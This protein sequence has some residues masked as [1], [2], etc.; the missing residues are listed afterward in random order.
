MV[1]LK[2]AVFTRLCEPYVR[3]SY[4]ENYEPDKGDTVV[5]VDVGLKTARS[6]GVV[7]SMDYIK[8]V[9]HY[10]NRYITLFVIPDS[11]YY[12]LH[13]QNVVRFISL[14]KKM[15]NVDNM[16]PILVVHYYLYKVDDYIE[17]LER[18]SDVFPIVFV[19]VTGN[20]VTVSPTSKI[21]CISHQTICNH[22][23]ETIVRDMLMRHFMVHVL[24]ITK[25]TLDYIVNRGIR[26]ASADTDKP[27]GIGR[28]KMAHRKEYCDVF[29][30]WLGNYKQPEPE[31][32][33]EVVVN[34]YGL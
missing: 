22:Y 21:K 27:R 25:P 18:L 32:W 2:F 3:L 33:L 30:E 10:A 8:Y 13:L 6:N 17:I 5:M 23:I 15:S 9:K 16:I 31:Q 12:P 14:A 20:I 34:D 29:R 4:G 19:G 26:I 11:W 28:E 7:V 24:G 1:Q